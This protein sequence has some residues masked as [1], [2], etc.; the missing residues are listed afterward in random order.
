MLA[1]WHITLFGGLRVQ[2]GEQVITR[3]KYQKVGCLLAY[4][5]YYPRQMH[6][7]E[8]LVELFWP[9]STLESGRANLSVA[10]SS[11]RHQLEPPGTP[12]GS[13]LRADRYSLG[14][15]PDMATSDVADFEQALRRA[16]E[17]GSVTERAQALERAI[18]LYQG[19]L[20]PGY[21]EDW[22][23]AEQARLMGLFG[24]AAE[25][26]IRLREEEGDL[27]EALWV[28]RH[29]VAVDPLREEGYEHL[30]RLLAA[31][32]QPGAALQQYRALEHLFEAEMGAE[33]S[34]ALR[35]L[36]RQIEKQFRLHSHA[37]VSL[38]PVP[39]PPRASERPSSRSGLPE[40]V[41]FLLT[42]IEG[43][44]HL[45][46]QAG[47][48][49]ALRTYHRTLRAVFAE[50]G[51]REI[52]ATG[53]AF[54]VS[55]P[56][57]RPALACAIASQQALAAQEWPK[58]VGPLKVRMALHTGDVG[59]KEGDNHDPALRRAS[60]MLTAAHGGQILLSEATA[61]LVRRDLGEETRLTDLG[62][63]RLRDV[64]GAERLYQ[65]D[66]PGMS[67]EA[68]PPLAAE[69]GRPAHLPSQLT[70]FF[71]REEEIA[72][73]TELLTTGHRPP[74]TESPSSVVG[75][76]SSVVRL[77]TLTGPGGTGKTRLAIEVAGRL[78]EAFGGAV[79]FVPLQDLT[80]PRLIP[81]AI[82]EGLGLPRSPGVELLQ[83]AVNFLNG[84]DAPSLLVLDNLEHLL[85]GARRKAE[86]GAAVVRALLE[87]VPTLTCLVTSRRSLNLEGEREF[88]VRPL[89]V[90]EAE[91]Q[92]HRDTE[93]S[94]RA[95][96]PRTTHHAPLTPEQLMQFASVQ[97]FLD[98][99]QG[100]RPDFQVTPGNAA[101]VAALCVRLEGIPLAIELAAAR[102]QVISPTQMLSQLEGRFAF[103]VSRRRD[104][105][106]RHRSLHAAIEWSYRLLPKELRRFFCRLSVFRGG[107][108]LEAAEAVCEEPL[109]LDYLAQ[110]RECSLILSEETPQEMRFRLLETLREYA[111]EQLS[112]EEREG[113][114]RRHA[115][116][117][118]GLAEEAHAPLFSENCSIW[119]DRLETEM[120]NL[121]GALDWHQA[122]ADS[123]PGLRLVVALHRYWDMRGY[124]QEGYERL[125]TMLRR[126]TDMTPD[127]L[128][129]RAFALVGHLAQRQ[130]NY[131]EAAAW[132]EQ[133]LAI[134]RAMADKHG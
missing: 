18:G 96:E 107:W 62:A 78:A 11:L 119:L 15:N 103:L 92:R 82:V 35:A 115:T 53:G 41:T 43:F 32:G 85:A 6:A 2:R 5:A 61:T 9:E 124:T 64:P 63:Y 30:I 33:P 37:A 55:F 95:F 81:G 89:P 51:G 117:F 23:L 111:D 65:A 24:D 50:Q 134:A 133:Q 47:F 122:Q 108:S 1:P 36:A 48:R 121:R 76:S 49:T 38:P 45:R 83:Q 28:A 120:E 31:A 42:D 20:L 130:G 59:F 68:F 19:R 129:A 113:A 12:A 90:P 127:P 16:R 46:Q 3:F 104:V 114:C 10:L 79:W 106:E 73:L 52:K 58:G 128:R 27:A 21:Y 44:T 86:D 22:V 77:V 105:T 74:T 131:A 102:M 126:G 123:S 56:I 100:V 80:A 13:V 93:D 66:Y 40:T 17:A 109:A 57:A 34:A 54:L 4:L 69:A 7:R 98:R 14:L 112:K 97:L 39:M 60:R 29:A 67:A 84:R 87:R 116:W 26:L 71:G 132:T 110:L 101:R 72:R 8:V 118:L 75:G 91:P 94:Q 70:R 25:A 99:A 125:K 88:P